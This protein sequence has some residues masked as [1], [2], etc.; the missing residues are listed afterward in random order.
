MFAVKMI[1]VAWIAGAVLFATAPAHADLVSVYAHLEDPPSPPLPDI[2]RLAD[3]GYTTIS[4]SPAPLRIEF[5]H[6]GASQQSEALFALV[7]SGPILGST[8]FAVAGARES[9]QEVPAILLSDSAIAAAIDVGGPPHDGHA[10]NATFAS[11]AAGRDWS[12]TLAANLVD[13]LIPSAVGQPSYQNSPARSM[14]VRAE[15]ARDRAR[16]EASQ[17]GTLTLVLT[18]LIGMAMVAFRRI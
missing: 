1:V 5:T 7:L 16:T 6:P 15:P 11:G 12:A 17:P 18:G 9:D 8:H 10:S 3:L 14:S 13:A 4:E 2:N